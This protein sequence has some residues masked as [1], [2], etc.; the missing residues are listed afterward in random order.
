MIIDALKRVGYTT[1]FDRSISNSIIGHTDLQCL[2]ICYNDYNEKYNNDGHLIRLP[3]DMHIYLHSTLKTNIAN[4]A[5][6]SV[7]VVGSSICHLKGLCEYSS[8]IHS[9]VVV[10]YGTRGNLDKVLDSLDNVTKSLKPSHHYPLLLENASGEGTELGVT[11]DEIRHVFEKCNNTKIGMC[12]DTCHAFSAGYHV[13]QIDQL[14]LLLE[15]LEDISSKHLRMIHL[16][17]SKHPCQSRKDR[18]ENI[19]QG[20]IWSNDKSS[21]DYLLDYGSDMQIDFILETPNS[22]TDLQYIRQNHMQLKRKLKL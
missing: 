7:Y 19:G 22:S 6:N 2:Q 10:H 11:V 18:H 1:R 4:T 17:D 20:Y 16:N 13:E 14:T 9:S 8:F 12:L 21:L 3:A 5:S 15:E